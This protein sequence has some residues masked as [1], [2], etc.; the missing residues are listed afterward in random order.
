MLAKGY[1]YA[2]I[3]KGNTGAFFFRDG[4]EPGDA[5]REWHARTTQVAR[6]AQAVVRQAYGKPG[7]AASAAPAASRWWLPAPASGRAGLPAASGW[8]GLPPAAR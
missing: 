4:K 5:M 7:S 3:D 8:T 6:A 1:A 2:S